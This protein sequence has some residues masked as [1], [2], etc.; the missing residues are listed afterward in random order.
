MIIENLIP[1]DLQTELEQIFSSD[2]FPWYF[3]QVTVNDKPNSGFQFVHRIFDD[4]QVTSDIF[5]KLSLIMDNFQSISGYE[6][7]KIVR[8]KAN[9]LTPAI[10]SEEVILNTFH[11]DVEDIND[12]DHVSLIYYVINSDGDTVID[13][14]ESVSPIKGRACYFNSSLFHRASNPEHNNRRIILNFVFRVK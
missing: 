14:K 7:K 2:V 4:G 9:L 8:I 1:S 13:G 5:P 10:L 6:I 11:R 12:N 3:N